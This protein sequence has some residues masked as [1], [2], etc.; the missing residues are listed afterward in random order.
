[1]MNFEKPQGYDEVQAGG[2]FT[3][4]ELGGHKLVV[5]KLEECTANS[6]VKYL[7]V[8]FDTAPDDAQPNYYAEQYKNDTRD[9]KKWGGVAAL[10]PTDREGNTSKTFKQ[11]CT[12]IERSNNS[13]I[14]WGADFESS[15]VGKVIGGV[16]GEEEYL[17]RDNEVRT[18]H[19]LFWW[20]STENIKDAK[21]PEKRTV[22]QPQ[23]RTADDTSWMDVAIG[24]EELPFK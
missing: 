21:I 17:N 16:F 23:V 14:K 20:R 13:Q 3:P 22:E 6:G 2:E 1:M 5:K 15:I 4:I 19:K 12:S 24:D 7:K 10:F 18:A 11:F 9:E 8:F